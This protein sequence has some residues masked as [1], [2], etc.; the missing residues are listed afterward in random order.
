[1]LGRH[2]QYM[3]TTGAH[4]SYTKILF[5]T[6]L[7]DS[8]L[9]HYSCV[10]INWKS[11]SSIWLSIK[12]IMSLPCLQLFIDSLFFPVKFQIPSCSSRPAISSSFIF[13]SLPSLKFL[14]SK[15]YGIYISSNTLS[16]FMSM[17]LYMC[18]TLCSEWPSLFL[19]CL[20][21]HSPNYNTSFLGMPPRYL[22]IPIILPLL[23]FGT[24]SMYLALASIFKFVLLCCNYLCICFSLLQ[25]YEVLV[26]GGSE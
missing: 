13:N 2:K 16:Y 26:G 5:N 19:V 7:L 20:E 1:M 22:L 21:Y 6:L 15:Y 12:Y 10:I 14:S 25:I 8:F 11:W 17:S 4:F 3:P 24:P 18:H 23:H 9:I